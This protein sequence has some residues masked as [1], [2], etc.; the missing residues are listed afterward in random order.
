[1]STKGFR[2]PTVPDADPE[3]AIM[4]TPQFEDPGFSSVSLKPFLG[5]SGPYSRDEM[6]RGTSIPPKVVTAM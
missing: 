4:D 5:R 6:N 2:P 3:G 1:M